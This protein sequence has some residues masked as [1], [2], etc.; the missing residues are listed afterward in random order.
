MDDKLLLTI[1]NKEEE[2]S[3]R[4]SLIALMVIVF[5]C[6]ASISLA[7]EAQT[8]VKEKQSPVMLTDAQLD[9]VVGAGGP[10][11]GKD[12]NNWSNGLYYIPGVP[13]DDIY[14]IDKYV[15]ATRTARPYFQVR[16]S[17]DNGKTNATFG[18]D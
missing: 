18:G 2:S 11:W 16:S 10:A 12:Y 6:F 5:M 1:N 13:G 15:G 3:M 8:P 7:E 9:N 4:T 14:S 17:T